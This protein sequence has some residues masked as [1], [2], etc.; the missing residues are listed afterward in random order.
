MERE[1]K[2]L[3]WK[4]TAISL[5]IIRRA[6]FVKMEDWII[7]IISNYLPF[8]RTFSVPDGEGGEGGRPHPAW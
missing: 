7:P 5:T 2:E 3:D 6:T 1:S 4:L 8:I